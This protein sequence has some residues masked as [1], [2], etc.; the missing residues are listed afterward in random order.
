LK[1]EYPGTSAVV[2]AEKL[3]R[4]LVSIQKQLREMGVGRRAKS[5]W[6]AAQVQYLRK[7]FKEAA[8]WE[9]ANELNKT[10]SVVKRKA[11]ELK[12][13]KG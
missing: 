11:A 4:S 12:L 9:I 2:L 1:K 7:N 13:K 3:K 8:A 6:T 5:E 10:P